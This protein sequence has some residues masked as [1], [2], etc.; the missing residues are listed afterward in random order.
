MNTAAPKSDTPRCDAECKIIADRVG[1]RWVT[2]NFARTIER[3]LA[4]AQQRAD[5]A[6]RAE[7][8]VRQILD[9]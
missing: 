4:A 1:N 9:T 3:E 2:L 7:Q 6:V 5:E 8:D